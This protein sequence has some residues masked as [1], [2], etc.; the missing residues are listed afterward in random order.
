MGLSLHGNYKY[1]FSLSQQT[2]AT[3]PHPSYPA[4]GRFI[5]SLY[6]IYRPICRAKFGTFVIQC[7]R[8]G[9]FDDALRYSLYTSM[10]IFVFRPVPW[11][12]GQNTCLPPFASQTLNVRFEVDESATS[13]VFLGILTFF[14]AINFSPLLSL[15]ASQSFLT[16]YHLLLCR[17]VGS[18]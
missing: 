8:D 2:N 17:F 15:L 13:L 14:P 16:H 3:I 12:S 5:Y 18:G 7:C 10:H 6:I 1:C 9:Y 11:P 4:T